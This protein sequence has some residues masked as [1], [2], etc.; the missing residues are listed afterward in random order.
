MVIIVTEMENLV[1]PAT[2]NNAKSVKNSNL[3]E[4]LIQLVQNAQ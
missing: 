1:Y 2:L 4:P 3:R